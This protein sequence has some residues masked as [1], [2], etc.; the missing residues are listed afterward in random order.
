[1][2][3]GPVRGRLLTSV[4]LLSGLLDD[5]MGIGEWDSGARLQCEMVPFILCTGCVSSRGRW[6]LL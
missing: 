6:W 1:M 2:R 3:G 5:M 4:L